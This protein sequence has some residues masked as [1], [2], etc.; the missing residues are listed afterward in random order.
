MFAN[1]HSLPHS[2]TDE[3][4]RK[5]EDELRLGFLIELK[6]IEKLQLF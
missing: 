4:R 3:R 2:S 5:L 1:T 6:G